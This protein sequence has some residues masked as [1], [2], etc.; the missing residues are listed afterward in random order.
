MTNIVTLAV[1]AT[2]VEILTQ[3]KLET[4]LFSP[5]PLFVAPARRNPLEFL[6]ETPQKLKW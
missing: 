3:F 5:P 6:N 2:D 1:S 4:G